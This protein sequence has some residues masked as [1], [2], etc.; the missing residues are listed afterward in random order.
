MPNQLAYLV[1]GSGMSIKGRDVINRGGEIQVNAGSVDI[2]AAGRFQNAALFDGSAH[3]RRDCLIFCDSSASSTVQSHGG[4]ISAS[5]DIRIRAASEAGNIG[6]RVLALQNLDISAPKV[7]ARGV[8]GYTAYQR[9]RGFKAWFSDSWARLY[10]M[11]IGGS[12]TA[13]GGRLAV[14]GEAVVDGGSFSAAGG[15][16][17]SAGMRIVRNPR[18]D[19]VTLENHLGLTSWFW[20]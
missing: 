14:D 18:R 13:D 17:A 8:L 16:D 2:V 9:D 15:V 7:Y 20:K 10:A 19:P 12:W 3:L 6:G 1:A 5:A 11:D 4:L